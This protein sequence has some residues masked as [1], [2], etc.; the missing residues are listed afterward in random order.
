MKRAAAIVGPTPS[1][2]RWAI[3][4]DCRLRQLSDDDLPYQ[5]FRQLR[6]IRELSLG[7]VEKRIL[8][9]IC[10]YP[11]EYDSGDSIR[12]FPVDE[13]TSLYGDTASLKNT[14][15]ECPANAVMHE[16]GSRISAGCYGILRSSYLNCDWISR[17]EKSSADRSAFTKSTDYSIRRLWFKVW[18]RNCWSGKPLSHLN[19]LVKSISM[20]VN[21]TLEMR[22]FIRAT[23]QC[24]EFD[25]TLETE[26][27]PA[28][29]SDGLNW[30]IEPHCSNC[31]NE[32]SE[33]QCC[34]ECGSRQIHPAMKKKV[35]GL[36]P[37]M[38]LKAIVGK[39]HADTL[40]RNAVQRLGHPDEE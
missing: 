39:E 37:Y 12:G 25:M 17:F 18:Q 30:K 10:I 8:D 24:V 23:H 31:R 38:L 40:A 14:C 34:S 27:I 26:L 20:E 16:S 36:R 5:T 29:Y 3:R 11:V 32:V 35:L 15:K 28:G 9:G 7:L 1:F 33:N 4:K 6:S 22:D 21:S 19:K 2:V 13:I